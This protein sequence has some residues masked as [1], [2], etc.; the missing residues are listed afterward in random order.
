MHE[1]YVGQEVLCGQTYGASDRLAAYPS[2][3]PV[4]PADIAKTVYYAMG[5]DNLDAVDQ[6]GQPFQLLEDGQPITGLF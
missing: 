6:N 1:T 2:D 4:G 5:I 3:K